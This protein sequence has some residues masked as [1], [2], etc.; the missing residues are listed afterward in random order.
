[1]FYAVEAG[2]V[3]PLERVMSAMSTKCDAEGIWQKY[4]PLNKDSGVDAAPLRV[5]WPGLGSRVML[6]TLLN[7]PA[8]A[9]E[10]WQSKLVTT[11]VGSL[12]SQQFRRIHVR[13]MAS[14]ISEVAFFAACA[15]LIA[16]EGTDQ[17]LADMARRPQG[18]VTL[19]LDAVLIVFAAYFIWIELVQHKASSD[20]G[21]SNSY[22]DPW[23]V[24]DLAS[25]LLVAGGAVAHVTRVPH[26]VLVSLMSITTILLLAKMLGLVTRGQS[27]FLPSHFQFVCAQVLPRRRQN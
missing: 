20:Y 5:P 12:W 22:A 4:R 19:L 24:C 1:V 11:V 15:I 27:S 18:V 9:K 17:T 3:E 25:Q 13:A 23:N 2:S 7:V 6:R 8:P 21:S 10:L 26:D 16:N 14:F